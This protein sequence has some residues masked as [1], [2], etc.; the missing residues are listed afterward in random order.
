MEQFVGKETIPRIPSITTDKFFS[1]YAEKNQPV[2]L[3]EVS[4]DW[5]CFQKWTKEKMVRYDL[6]H[7]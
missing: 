1:E 5:P 7:F 3:T 4:K 6:E 2:I